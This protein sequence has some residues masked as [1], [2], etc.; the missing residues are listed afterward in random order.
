M[1][2]RVWSLCDRCGQKFYRS[3]LR[4]ETTNFVVCSACFDGK[5]DRKNHPQNKSARPRYESKKV[6]DGRPMAVPDI[7]YLALESG[8]FLLTETG[9]QIIVTQTVWSPSMTSPS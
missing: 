6:P 9:A 1:S 4:K 8:G 3:K 5:F 7:S 2:V